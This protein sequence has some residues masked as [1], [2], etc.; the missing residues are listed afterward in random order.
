MIGGASIS[1]YAQIDVRST[2]PK[3]PC[4]TSWVRMRAADALEKICRVHPDW[5]EPYIDKFSSDFATSTQPSIQWHMAQIYRQVQLTTEQKEFAIKW[6]KN[7]LSSTTTDWIVSA[8][9]MD[10]L[11]KLTQE[12]LLSEKALIPLLEIQ[13]GHKTNAVSNRA[14]KLLTELSSK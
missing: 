10:S 2:L 5:L 8:N 4:V 3:L 6:L 9:A 14:H 1:E 13:C 11:A 7:L 12:G